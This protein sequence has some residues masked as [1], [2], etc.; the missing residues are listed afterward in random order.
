MGP[1]CIFQIENLTQ[2]HRQNIDLLPQLP[3]AGQL[4]SGTVII[5]F[6]HS[7]VPSFAPLLNIVNSQY[8]SSYFLL[9]AQYAQRVGLIR[10]TVRENGARTQVLNVYRDKQ[11]QINLLNT[12]ACTVRQKVGYRLYLNGA[13]LREYADPEACF[14]SDIAALAPLRAAMVGK[15]VESQKLEADHLGFLGDID[16][17]Q[18]YGGALEERAVLAVTGQTAPCLSVYIPP[19]VY[20]SEPAQLFYPGYMGAP[21][22]RIPSLLQTTRGTLLAAIDQRMHGPREHPNKIHIVLRRSTDLGQSFGPGIAVAKM[23]ENSQSID[24]CLLQDS[25]TGRIF[26]LTD[27]FAENTTLQTAGRG[28]GFERAGG[29]IYRQLLDDNGVKY[30]EDPGGTVT[31][32]GRPTPYTTGSGYE[33]FSNGDLVGY[34]FSERCPLRTYPTS[35]L[36]LLYS[37]DDG[38]TWSA[39]QQLN[40]FVKEGW[41]TFLGCSPGRGIQLRRGAHAGRLLFP[42]YYV[43]PH[44]VQCAALIY[45]DDHGR[46]WRRGESCN[47]HRLFENQLHHSYTITDKR[48]DTSEPQ[49]VEL[50]T[51]TV[52]MFCKSPFSDAGCVAV[53]VSTDGGVSFDSTVRFDPA[54]PSTDGLSVISCE[55][56]L[57]G[58]DALIYAGGDSITGSCNG[59][60]K[61]GLV[62]SGPHHPIDWRYSRLVKPGTFGHCSLSMITPRMVGLF[63]ESSGGLDMSFMRM[64]LAFLKTEDKPLHPV[65]LANVSF[66]PQGAGTLCTLQFNQT[67]MLCGDRRLKVRASRHA[68][69]AHYVSRS[70]DCRAYCFLAPNLAPGAVTSISISTSMRVYSTNGM[71]YIYSP[72]E[73]RFLWQHRDKES[74]YF[75]SLFASNLEHFDDSKRIFSRGESWNTAQGGGLE[76]APPGRPDAQVGIKCNSSQMAQLI[77]QYVQRNYALPLTLTALAR[78]INVNA[79]YLGRIFSRY[80]GQSFNE[81]VAAYRIAQARSLLKN[82]G[83]MVWEIAQAVGYGDLDHFYLIFKKHTGMSPTAY[84]RKISQL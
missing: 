65:E 69:T 2:V 45:S 18:I 4:G 61:L 16:F 54:L 84:R 68:K 56:K 50:S 72:G 77:M 1:E 48:L 60:V 42:V 43:N 44:G 38:Q 64:D 40:P 35:Y 32:E 36:V 26:L 22:Y 6:R 33:L 46:S 14:L 66:A 71:C 34:T 52:M 78:S 53:A 17:L 74:T 27:H 7:E 55:G 57:E 47:D 59:A 28:T 20:C 73:K 75:F 8:P 11:A 81:Y 76:A 82:D 12:I 3:A 58:C 41:M 30:L 79:A 62:Q 9:Y 25:C 70:E 51:G 31:R 49:V 21:N 10:K 29:T 24:S 80:T 63:Y 37:D 15:A 67:V 5:R 39:P 83:L 23:P 13:L 19:N